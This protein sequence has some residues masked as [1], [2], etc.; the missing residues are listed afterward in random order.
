[1]STFNAQHSQQLKRKGMRLAA[2]NRAEHLD[3]V[4]S[5][6]KDHAREH[7][8]VTADDVG[9]ALQELA[10]KSSL[11]PA[12]GSIFAGNDWVW[13]GNFVPSIRVSNHGRLLREWMLNSAT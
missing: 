4:R 7:G 6:A 1:M 2:R 5:L 10:S 12:A 3:Y 8:T 13:T 9:R 11:G